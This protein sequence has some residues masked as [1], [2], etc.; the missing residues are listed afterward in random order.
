MELSLQTLSKQKEIFEIMNFRLLQ[1]NDSEFVEQEYIMFALSKIGTHMS[2]DRAGMRTL[3]LKILNKLSGH[4][5]YKNMTNKKI[6]RNCM[7]YIN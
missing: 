3:P 1:I 4:R 7:T 5:L 2:M 6:S